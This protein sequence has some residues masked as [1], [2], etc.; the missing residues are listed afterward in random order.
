MV[1]VNL[2]DYR[3]PAGTLATLRELLVLAAKGK[4]V[5]LRFSVHLKDGTERSGTTGT[6]AAEAPAANSGMVRLPVRHLKP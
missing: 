1:V 3:R 6:F 4:I 5:G 2:R